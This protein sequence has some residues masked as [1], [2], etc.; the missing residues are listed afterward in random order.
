M[1]EASQRRGADRIQG[2]AVARLAQRQPSRS[3][4]K[5]AGGA[6]ASSCTRAGAPQR[7]LPRLHA[8]HRGDVDEQASGL[9][10]MLPP[11]T[12][13][14]CS[15]AQFAMP[16]MRTSKSARSRSGGEPQRH[17]QVP[18]PGAHG[19][20]V[21]EVHRRRLVAD[22]DGRHPATVEVHPLDQRIRGHDVE[23][24]ALR[25]DDG[26]VVANPEQQAMA[27]AG[28]GKPRPQAR[29]GRVRRHRRPSGASPGVLDGP[30][31]ADDRDL[32]IWPGYSSSVSMRRAMSFDSQTASSSVTCSAST[33]A[34][35]AARLQGEGLRD[36]LE[37]VGQVFE[38]LEP[39]HVRLEDVAAGARTRRRDGVGRLHEH[40]LE[41]RPVDVHV[42]GGHRVDDRARFP[43]LLQGTRRPVRRGEPP[44]SRSMALP[45]SC[46]NAARVVTPTSSP[47]SRAMTP[48]TKA[49]S[50]E[51]SSTFWP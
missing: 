11:A 41:R 20:Q 3:A 16:S 14:R 5:L 21:A 37:R 7:H 1:T 39:F 36:A 44:R 45:M 13:A 12:T 8:A 34:D 31:L 10:V 38:L 46:R 23:G 50:R 15:A 30:G 43:V 24:V 26:R 40:R 49:T 47:T 2:V 17:Q 42:M 33:N 48:A 35:L 27:V 6:C 28:R 25:R 32:S 4:A 29:S 51:W 19:A 22:V 9:E 18:R